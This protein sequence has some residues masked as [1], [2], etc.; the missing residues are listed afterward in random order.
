MLKIDIAKNRTATALL[1]GT[2]YNDVISV[3]NA[4]FVSLI[5]ILLSHLLL[6]LVLRYTNN[7]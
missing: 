3:I 4:I 7:K 1:H 6:K 2:Y 5:K